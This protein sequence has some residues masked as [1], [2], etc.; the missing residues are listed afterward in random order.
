M[1]PRNCIAGILF[2]LGF[3]TTAVGQGPHLAEVV[4]DSA[5]LRSGPGSQMPD[6]GSLT[7]G[8]RV[9]V[10]KEEGDWLAI[11]PPRGQISWIK[12]LYLGPVQGQQADQTPRNAIIHADPEVAIAAGKPGH[13]T[14]LD[15]QRTKIPDQTI[16]MIIG[17]K[18]EYRGSQWY[19]IEPPDGDL[20]YL[21]KSAVRILKA[22][23][24]KSF[25]VREGQPQPGQFDDLKKG[26]NDERLVASVPTSPVNSG[27]GRP[28]NWPNH[29]LWHQAEDA[30]RRSDYAVAEQL[31]LKLAA[32]MNR[33]DGDP[34]L[35][36][37][38]YTRVHSVR[39]KLRQQP[40]NRN[41]NQ[42]GSR[43]V[44]PGTLREAGF[45]FDRRPTYALVNAQGKVEC[46]AI[47]G[48]GVDLSRFVRQEVELFGSIDFPGDLRGAGV[49]TAGQVRSAK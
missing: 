43:W 4:A 44:G 14:P 25:V 16:V 31:Y 35:A 27:S 28:G 13:V 46:Y 39:E 5:V 42:T 49:M 40:D 21:H 34:E 29:P 36:N 12:H 17:P 26:S 38:C 10:E 23:P 48:N 33:A 2:G 18:V 20:R 7:R 1:F 9:I 32:E 19:P 15:I 47:E 24:S 41:G 6:T 8:T 37:L 11:Q 22:E 45:R 30:V 3:A